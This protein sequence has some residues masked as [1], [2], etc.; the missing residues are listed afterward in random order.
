MI[1]N[2][3]PG[4]PT[5][6][7]ADEPLLS[8]TGLRVTAGS[9]ALAAEVSFDLD[10]GHCIAFVG[11]SGGGKSLT[12]RALINLLPP[13][14][15]ASGQITYAGRHLYSPRPAPAR[16]WRAVRGAGIAYIAQDALVSLDPL[17]TVGDEVIES[18]LIHQQAQ[19]RTDAIPLLRKV[20]FPEPERHLTHR[21]HQLSG[22]MRQRALIASGLSANPRILIADEPTTALDQITQQRIVELLQQI[23]REGTALILVSHD[24]NVVRHVADTV[25]VFRQGSVVEQG[26]T[27]TVLQRPS[28]PYTQAL[29]DAARLPGEPTP[30]PVIDPTATPLIRVVGVT[31]TFTTR[32]ALTTTTTTALDNVSLNLHAGQTLGVLGESGSGKSTLTRIILGLDIPTAG[33]TIM[34]PSPHNPA[35]RAKVGWVPQDP[36][37]AMNPRWPVARII[38]EGVNPRAP[39]QVSQQHIDSLAERVGLSSSLLMRRPH[40]LSGGQRQRAVIARALAG[41]PDILVCD[42]ATS[43]LDVTVQARILDLIHQVQSD[44]GVAVLFVSHDVR[45][46]RRIAHDVVVMRNGRVVEVGPTRQVFDAPTHPYT[47]DLLR[48]VAP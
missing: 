47:V 5:A 43:A 30:K 48:S 42:E 38:A 9:Q 35:H 40:Q 26:P 37:S 33:A 41:N 12:A 23:K 17:R 8:V 7:V 21:S 6:H 44:L 22:G 29:I 15:A 28:S 34:G 18:G 27:S 36:L 19:Q 25:L 32:S 3:T 46:V 45:V 4:A 16:I 1:E 11:E 10:P 31:K 2:T 39:R 14:V 20:A 13:G 24:I